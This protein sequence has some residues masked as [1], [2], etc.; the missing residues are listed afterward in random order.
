MA[1]ATIAVRAWADNI[2][3]LEFPRRGPR[4]PAPLFLSRL[5]PP[6][7]FDIGVIL[8]AR[9]VIRLAYLDVV[10]IRSLSGATFLCVVNCASCIC[11]ATTR[12]LVPMP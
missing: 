2:D 4:S 7:E 5:V 12:Q 3:F 10:K 9:G 1:E 11:G 6:A 8:F